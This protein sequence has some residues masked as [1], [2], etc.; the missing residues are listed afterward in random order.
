[1][2]FDITYVYKNTANTLNTSN[3]I[4]CAVEVLH[5]GHYHMIDVPSTIDVD[6]ITN[7][8]LTAFIDDRILSMHI[9]PKDTDYIGILLS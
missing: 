5:D 6:D 8:E 2:S 4:S 3:T 7:P 9:A 1:M